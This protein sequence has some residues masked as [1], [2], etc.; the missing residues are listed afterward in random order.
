MNTRI[1]A[2]GRHVIFD[3]V[4]IA[5][6]MR[7]EKVIA[8]DTETTGL[9]P[10]RDSLAI[11]QFY[12][13]STGVTGIVQCRGGNV[14]DA[15]RDLFTGDH[16]FVAH[17]AISFDILFLANAG[18]PWAKARWFDTLVGETVVIGSG[19][20]DVSAALGPT[21]K[22]RLGVTIDKTIDHTGWAREQLTA[23]QIEYA[24]GDIVHL[25]DLM[26]AQIEIAR[27]SS[28]LEALKLEQKLVKIFAQMTL[29][30]LPMMPHVLDNF[31]EK[32]GELSLKYHRELIS[33]LGDINY[34]SPKQL[35]SALS[36]RGVNLVDT[37]HETL[38]E[39]SH[40][41]LPHYEYVDALLNYRKPAQRLK[42]YG[43]SWRQRYL[44]DGLVHPRFWPCGTDTGRV[45]STDPNLQQVPK[46]GRFLIGNV[47]GYKI[48]SCDYSQIEVRV[49]AFIANDTRLMQLLESTDVHTT[50]ASDV[51]GVPP[52]QVSPTQRKMSKAITFTMLFAG[53]ADTF[54]RHAHTMGAE[55]SHDDAERIFHDFLQKFPGISEQ[56]RWAENVSR[57]P[58]VVFIRLKNGLRRGLIGEKKRPSVIVNTV[59]QGNA[60]I[61]MKTGLLL[62]AERGLLPYLGATVHDE[63]VA[64]VPDKQA[65]EFG[66]ELSNAMI[67]G[68]AQLIPV[69]ITTETVIHSNWGGVDL[70]GEHHDNG[71]FD[72]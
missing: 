56:R 54:Y 28:Q 16:L 61:G 25:P 49:A 5:N 41:K 26:A 2:D 7:Q 33:A 12:G 70:Q 1:T 21:L 6:A 19:R 34:N 22:R 45:S 69:K 46:D 72:G 4:D 38:V 57:K 50:I 53:S 67:D 29:N 71:D 58:G 18:V 55:I 60:A 63:L 64:A 17:N 11:M 31:L 27:E 15:I 20:R 24:T 51:F 43:G 30:G 32:Q 44:I 62:A 35:L 37:R 3:P 13:P 36:A 14:P 10:W 42:M 39:Y 68:M 48:V 59:V 65:E 40:N 8:F 9:S 23:E 66:Q 52:E 47:P